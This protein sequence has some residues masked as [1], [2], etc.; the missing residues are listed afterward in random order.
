M[1]T[2]HEIFPKTLPLGIHTA[3]EIHMI[4]FLKVL[5]PLKSTLP[6]V[7]KNCVEVTITD[8]DYE[9]INAIREAGLI[10][11]SISHVGGFMTDATV[12]FVPNCD[13]DVTLL[14]KQLEASQR[15]LET[16]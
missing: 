4:G 5:E 12:V 9:Y 15:S 10:Q 2:Q 8:H 1:H 7:N 13:V 11:I 14:T 6:A 16:T 3:D